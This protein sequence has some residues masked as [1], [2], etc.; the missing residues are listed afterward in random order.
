VKTMGTVWLVGMMGAGKTTVG[1]ALAERLRWRFVD[2]D[3]EIEERAGCTV[4][5][6]FATEGE[7]AFRERERRAVEAL[8][9]E[10][11]VVALGGGAIA[12]PEVRAKVAGTGTLVYLRAEPETLAARLGPA[13]ER[14]LLAGRGPR[15]RLERLRELLL[16]REPAYASATLTVET[17]GATPE[18]VMERIACF[19][20]SGEDGA[21]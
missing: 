10:E 14:P 3:A 7:A 4:A 2:T 6:I 11:A 21:R 9:G 15:E 19:L 13:D 1:R 17:D 18:Q 5:E 20:S 16:E 8:A 12:Q